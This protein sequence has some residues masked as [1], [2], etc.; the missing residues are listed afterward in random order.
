VSI[1]IALLSCTLYASVLTVPTEH[2]T[3]QAAI[4]AAVAGDT[5]IVSP[6]TYVENINFGGK[7]I[8]LTS[9]APTDPNVVA[10]TIIDGNAAGL[11]VTFGGTET[12][13]CVLRGFTVRDGHGILGNGT[14]ATIEYCRIT[15]NSDYRGSYEGGGLAECDGLINHCT[16]DNNTAFGGTPFGGMGGGLYDCDG[17]IT[18]CM[19]INNEAWMS[20]Y[21]IGGEGGGLYD[22]D[23]VIIN[24]TITGNTADDNGGG[25]HGCDGP[26]TNCTIA[27][28]TSS[29]VSGGGLYDCDG[30]ITNCTITGNTADGSGGGLYY[31]DASITNCILW[32]NSAVYSGDQLYDSSTPTYSCIQDWTGGGTGNIT[33]DPLFAAPGYVDANDTSWPWD[34]FWVNGDYHLQSEHGRWDPNMVQ[35]VYDHATSPCIDVGDPADPNWMHELWPHGGR[36]NMGAYG[37]TPL[38]SMSANANLDH[39]IDNAVDTSD[40][41]IFCQDWLLQDTLLDTDLNL[42]GV[43]DIA[44]F[45]VFSAQWLWSQP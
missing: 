8:I 29:Y 7:D 23:G 33:G 6:G 13:A 30:P 19:I 40:L 44:D 34:D 42:D 41:L 31:C 14:Q 22:C 45:A 2:S 27:G 38:A 20:E 43:V 9:T 4:D 24:C 35:W 16:I 17:T 15:G 26:I 10:A 1:G 28:N 12:S 18:H 36:I 37:G 25:L 5:I 11:V 3:I 21:D 39:D 32:G